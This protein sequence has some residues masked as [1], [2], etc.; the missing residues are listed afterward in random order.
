[1]W[2][3]LTFWKYFWVNLEMKPIEGVDFY[4]CDA[5]DRNLHKMFKEKY[6]YFDSIISDMAPN[7]SG[8]SFETH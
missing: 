8:V 6:G 4:K 7:F 5:R 1:M 3:Q 2:Y